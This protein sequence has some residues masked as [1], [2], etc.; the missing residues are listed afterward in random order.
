MKNVKIVLKLYAP[1]AM[2]VLIALV[3]LSARIVACVAIVQTFVKIVEKYA[4]IVRISARNV[5]YVRIV[6]LKNFATA[7]VITV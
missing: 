2:N 4:V 3:Q 6:Y 1:I 5:I 7:V